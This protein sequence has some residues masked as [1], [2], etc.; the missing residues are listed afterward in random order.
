MAINLTFHTTHS[1]GYPVA[2]QAQAQISATGLTVCQLFSDPQLAFLTQSQFDDE[3]VIVSLVDGSEQMR[4]VT[5]PGRATISGL[6]YNKFGYR[7][8]CSFATVTPDEVIAIDPDTGAEVAAQLWSANQNMV[9]PQG[10]GCNGLFFTRCYGEWIELRTIGGLFIADRQYPGR[11]I[12]GLT[13]AHVGWCHVDNL[14]NELV[15]LG[16]FGNEAAI[17]PAP[18]AA[19]GCHA[20]AF[21]DITDHQSAPQVWLEH[22]TI[23]AVGTINHPD[24]PWNPPPWLG[25]HRIYIAN[26][27]DGIIYAGYLTAN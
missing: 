7:I 8:W 3:L 10:L 18:G 16:P 21:D 19:G 14:T 6:A 2:A 12:K 9:N 22:G 4:Y 27:V 1:F 13:A 23:G 20:I 15:V 25:R 26:N 24:T 5:P 17:A 11:D